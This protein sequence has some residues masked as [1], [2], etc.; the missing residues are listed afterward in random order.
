M[1]RLLESNSIIK[2]ISLGFGFCIWLIIS[3]NQIVSITKKVPLCF[4][5]QPQNCT[6]YAAETI[7]ISAFGPKKYLTQTFSS[8]YAIHLNLKNY[9]PGNH[10]IELSNHDLFLPQSVKL[11]QLK[12][13]LLQIKIAQ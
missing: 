7:L 3:Q 13:T 2:L 9:Q 11:L 6:V 8:E 4:Y 12:P 1:N 10:E 5:N